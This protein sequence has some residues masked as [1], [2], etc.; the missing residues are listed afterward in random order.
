MVSEVGLVYICGA[1]GTCGIYSYMYICR[2]IRGTSD[3]KAP[4]ILVSP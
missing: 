3:T 2:G 4:Q 1:L